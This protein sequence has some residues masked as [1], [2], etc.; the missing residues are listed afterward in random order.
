[1]S[2]AIKVWAFG[3]CEPPDGKG[4]NTDAPPHWFEEEPDLAAELYG[5]EIGEG[6]HRIYVLDDEGQKHEFPVK[7]QLELHARVG[8][9]RRCT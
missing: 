3:D 1:M 8:E 6:E 2:I 9:P 5:L 4:H 7:V